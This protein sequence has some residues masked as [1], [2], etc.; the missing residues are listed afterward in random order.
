MT[1]AQNESNGTIMKIF[2]RKEFSTLDPDFSAGLLICR[3]SLLH[4]ERT[5]LA[6]LRL[7]FRFSE[8]MTLSE[9][10]KSEI[11]RKE[12]EYQGEPYDKNVMGLSD[13]YVEEKDEGDYG[14]KKLAKVDD[15]AEDRRKEIG[16]NAQP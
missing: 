3:I 9:E 8:Q 4:L 15:M 16:G 7:P 2:L 12:E 10:Q 5:P 1:I 13:K 6:R 11:L 14:V